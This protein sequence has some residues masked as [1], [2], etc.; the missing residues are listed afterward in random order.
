MWDAYLLLV[1]FL[2]SGGFLAHDLRREAF[3]EEEED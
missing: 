2:L 1:V 3:L